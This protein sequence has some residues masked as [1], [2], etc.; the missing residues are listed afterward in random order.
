MLLRTHY[1]MSGTDVERAC[2]RWGSTSG[3]SAAA[4]TPSSQVLLYL[5]TPFLRLLSLRLLPP[6]CAAYPLPTPCKVSTYGSHYSYRPTPSLRHA[7]D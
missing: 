3:D 7:R 5:P 4:S 6:P 2:T 1:G